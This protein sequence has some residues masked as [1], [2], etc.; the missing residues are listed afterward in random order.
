MF[1]LDG[2]IFCCISLNEIEESAGF[3]LRKRDILCLLYSSTIVDNQECQSTFH[4]CCQ[5]YQG[6]IWCS[7]C[8]Q[9]IIKVWRW[10]HEIRVIV[11][12]NSF[13]GFQKGCMVLLCLLSQLSLL[14][15]GSR[16]GNHIWRRE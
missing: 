8:S 12:P 9:D 5:I 15:R 16:R 13:N 11:P 2:H 3:E 6:S 7:D 10:G 1:Q 4:S 14:L